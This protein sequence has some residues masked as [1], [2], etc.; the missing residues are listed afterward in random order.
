[1]HR[2]FHPN[3]E[4]NFSV[5]LVTK[6]W[7][8]VHRDI[9]MSPSLDILKNHL[10]VFGWALFHIFVSGMG[11]GIEGTFSMFTD[12]TKLSAAVTLDGV[13]AIQRDLDRSEGEGDAAGLSESRPKDDKPELE[14]KS[15]A[16]LRC[17]YTNARTMGNKQ[18]ELEAMVQQQNHDVVAI[19][20]TWWDDSHSWR[21]ALDGYKLFR[22]DRKG[23]RVGGVALYIKEAFD[24]RG[25]LQFM[26]ME[27]NAYRP[28]SL[29]SVPGMIV[30]QFILRV[31]MQHLQ[32]GQGIRPSQQGFRRGR[33]CLTNLVSFYDQVTGLVGAGRAVDVVYLDSS[34]AFGTVSHSTLLEKLQPTAGTGALSAGF[35]TG[36]MAGPESAEQLPEAFCDK[37]TA[38]ID[39]GREVDVIYL[40]FL[41]AFDAISSK[42]LKEQLRK[43]RLTE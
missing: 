15:V 18:E 31:I 6:L 14:E 20:E 36:C 43:G 32:D 3:I 9:M 23:R 27:L 37:M 1:M 33:S 29:T 26:K 7:I 10:V 42:I 25:I 5:V 30:K 12:D 39:E 19:T 28:D 38:C 2:K 4:N 41:E 24:S 13:D 8:R 11:S 40:D 35:R 17:T 34:K 22:R 16:Q 21:T